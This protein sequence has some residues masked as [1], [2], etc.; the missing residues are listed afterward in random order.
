MCNIEKYLNYILI[1]K[2]TPS[3]PND[4]LNSAKNFYTKEKNIQNWHC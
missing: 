4:I 2:K 1:I 3:N